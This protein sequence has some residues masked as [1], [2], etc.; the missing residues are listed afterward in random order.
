MSD[1]YDDWYDMRRDYLPLLPDDDPVKLAGA[2]IAE[3]GREVQPKEE[4]KKVKIQENVMSI[5][6][7][8]EVEG[9]VLKLPPGQ[10]DRSTYTA[11]NKVLECMGGKWSR[12]AR[13]HKFEVSPA[14][15]VDS[16]MLTGE[17]V[18]RI[19]EFQFYPTPTELAERMVM[20][21]DIQ[22]GMTVLEPSAG[23]GAIAM[24]I[25][26]KWDYPLLTMVELDEKHIPELQAIPALDVFCTNFLDTWPS[27]RFDRIVANPPFT[28]QQDI[29]HVNHMLDWLAPGG[30]LVS[31][32]SAGVMFSQTKKAQAFRARIESLGGEF[33]KLDE[34]TF[35]E[36]GTGVNTVL[37]VV[38]APK[39]I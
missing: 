10:L 19:K 17:V 31:V 26:R 39:E 37:L 4:M 5:L 13:G 23:N 18:D 7:G 11:V 21:A 12:H 28:R 34:G 15:L 24:A 3:I 30:R 1:A 14:D 32:M 35:K 9:N 20:I 27:P 33:E 2:V 29:D 16:V 36:S 22:E 25:A 38:D 6:S 8:C